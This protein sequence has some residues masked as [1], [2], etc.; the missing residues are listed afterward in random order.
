[1][2][3]MKKK[4]IYN[5]FYIL[6]NEYIFFGSSYLLVKGRATLVSI[7]RK[8]RYRLHYVSWSSMFAPRKARLSVFSAPNSVD[9]QS[10][11]IEAG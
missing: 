9:V 2:W 8:Q 7:K 5:T 6:I 4:Y 10:V 3:S 11:K 1:M